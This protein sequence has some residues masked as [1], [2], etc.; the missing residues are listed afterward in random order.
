MFN[1]NLLKAKII[2]KNT[3]VMK[4]ACEIGVCET[5]FY[6]K[7]ARGGDFSRFEIAKIVDALQLS[8]EERDNIFFNTQLAETQE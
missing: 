6:R 4:L 8:K 7:M 2:E 1:Q 5:T 3:S